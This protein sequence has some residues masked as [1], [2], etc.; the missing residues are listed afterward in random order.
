LH[1]QNLSADATTVA[2]QSD[3]QKNH[4]SVKK[5]GFLAG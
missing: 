4:F 2:D 1:G 3:G 5:V